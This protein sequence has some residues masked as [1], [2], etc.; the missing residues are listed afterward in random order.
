TRFS[1]DWSSDVCSSDLAIF[2]L[3]ISM[4]SFPLAKAT[5]FIRASATV[6]TFT[7]PPVEPGD[8]PIHIKV[9]IIIKVGIPRKPISKLL[10]PADLDELAMKIE[11][12]HFPHSD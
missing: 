10:N 6:V 7:P 11:L 8:T 9:D 2:R 3:Y 5:I 1:R 4:D 12:T